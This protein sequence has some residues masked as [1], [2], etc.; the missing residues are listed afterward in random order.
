MH[1]L[2]TVLSLLFIT[3]VGVVV[4]KGFDLL[5]KKS[6]LSVIGLGYGLGVGLI[7]AQMYLYARMGVLWN[8][9]NLI[10]PWVILLIVLGLFNKKRER[11]FALLRM[12]RVQRMDFITSF[13]LVGISVSVL[14]TIFE[15][16]IRPLTVWDGWAA[17]MIKSKAFFLDST[18]TIP[19]LQYIRSDG[20]LI[21]SLLGS[22]VYVVLGKIDDTAV[23]LASSAFYIALLSLFYGVLKERYSMRYALFFT[24]LLA[25]TQVLIRQGGR[26]EAGQADLPLGYFMF[27]VSLLL[28]EYVKTG[29]TKVLLLLSVFLGIVSLIKFEGLPFALVIIAMLCFFIYKNK[30]YFYFSFLLFWVIPVLD[31]QLFKQRTQLDAIYF[32]G[33]GYIFS[34]S[35]IIHAF[36]GSIL[37]LVTV[38]SWNLLWIVYF[39]C[40]IFLFSK[41]SVD[42][43][44]L[45][46]IVLSQLGLYLF[47]YFFTQGNA[48]ESS[49]ER[50]LV[51]LAPLA[52]L[53]VAYC[54]KEKI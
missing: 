14:Y 24:F 47:I 31:W 2:I 6:M 38:K 46:G 13:L 44:L 36:T 4:I 3:L 40:L 17:W 27:A 45:H 52:L 43:L 35:K 53:V 1:V 15:A 19:T 49:A 22:F 37:A 11:F 9:P 23:L 41:K 20:P 50:L 16:L 8:T 48:P 54:T 39:Y 30:Q 33:H 51:H 29:K 21:V 42:I 32:E 25:T 12:T 28:L 18:I 10:L 26:L 34:V 7:T 5:H